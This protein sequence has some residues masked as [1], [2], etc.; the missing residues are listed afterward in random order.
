MRRSRSNPITD[1]QSRPWDGYTDADRERIR[2][3]AARSVLE[4]VDDNRSD[5]SWLRYCERH[6]LDPETAAS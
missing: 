4:D 5:P 1:A 2:R 3:E 6:G